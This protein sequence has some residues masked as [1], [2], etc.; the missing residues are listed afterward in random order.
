MPARE[1]LR[2]DEVKLQFSL[3]ALVGK[4]GIRVNCESCGEEIVNGRE[5]HVEL[6]ILCGHCTGER[7][8][9]PA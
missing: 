2:V 8:W 4:P 5:R 1:L 9:L 6:R 3:E 7:Y